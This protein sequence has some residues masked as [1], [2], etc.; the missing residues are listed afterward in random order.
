MAPQ[1]AKDSLL[2]ALFGLGGHDGMARTAALDGLRGLAALMVFLVHYAAL[3]APWLPEGGMTA[4]GARGLHAAGHLGV[5]LFFVISGYLIYGSLIRKE[6]AFRAYMRRRLWRIYPTFLVVFAVYLA[7]SAALPAQSRI[8][9]EPLEAIPYVLANLLLL[10][11]L[12]DIAPIITVA[13]S[14]SYEMFFYL[15]MPLLVGALALRQR[16]RALRVLVF[17]LI[18]I[19]IPILA[20]EH[21]AA[22]AFIVG[23]MLVETTGALGTRDVPAWLEP[24][25]VLAFAAAIGV[26]SAVYLDL[27]EGP[28]ID[29]WKNLVLFGASYLL[30]L[31]SL[32]RDGWLARL[33]RLRLA[34]Y[35]GNVSYSF[36]LIHSLCLH[37]VFVIAGVLLPP[38]SL[39]HGLWF[40][41]LL[42]PALLAS[43]LG[44]A[45]LFLLVERPFSLDG[46]GAWS[47]LRQRRGDGLVPV[48][49]TL[50]SR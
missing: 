32:Q 7:L 15:V 49:V 18:W 3:V 30:F 16:P 48:K 43:T 28:H 12:F 47:L 27:I 19:L 37:V 1:T 36:Y 5:Y 44:A 39:A 25:A 22:S 21:F 34:R 38:E 2:E 9:P 14:L 33:F 6:V 23:I 45:A 4:G 42:P 11:G 26:Y 13:W 40:W 17:A 41:V 20:P 10:P 8:P 46:F 29:I 31:A 35:V 24:V 50:E